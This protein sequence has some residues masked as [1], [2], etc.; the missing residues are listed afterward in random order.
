MS[1]QASA[2]IDPAMTTGLLDPPLIACSLVIGS[3]RSVVLRERD[4]CDD[5][6]CAA[7]GE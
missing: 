4:R 5:E 7:V 1:T 2:R 6:Q 3:A